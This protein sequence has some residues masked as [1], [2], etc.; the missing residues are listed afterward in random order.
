MDKIIKVNKN[1][2]NVKDNSWV[3]QLTDNTENID[4]VVLKLKQMLETPEIKDNTK[5][6]ILKQLQ[7][8]DNEIAK[9]AKHLDDMML[10]SMAI[11]AFAST[12]KINE[13]LW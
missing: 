11:N 2:T 6:K 9:R 5:L 13:D 7:E 3:G 8:I 1:L 12:E 10:K 4:F